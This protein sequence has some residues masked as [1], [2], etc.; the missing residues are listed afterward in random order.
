[1]GDVNAILNGEIFILREEM[2]SIAN[3]ERNT[4]AV[5]RSTK[6]ENG[7]YK[8][9]RMLSS[10]ITIIQL[11]SMALCMPFFM[12]K[13]RRSVLRELYNWIRWFSRFHVTSRETPKTN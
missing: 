4:K 10:S 9:F 6:R 13:E 7:L 8:T 5:E 1:M 3:F 12:Q 2:N 11:R